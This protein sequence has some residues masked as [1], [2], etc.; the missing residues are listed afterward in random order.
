MNIDV[1]VV[2]FIDE[3]KEARWLPF[4]ICLREDLGGLVEFN[5]VEGL[6]TRTKR[7]KPSE[8]TQSRPDGNRKDQP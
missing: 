5:T 2:C 6:K 7:G 3:Q 8:W 4:R 1:E